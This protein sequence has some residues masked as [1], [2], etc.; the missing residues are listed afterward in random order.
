MDSED[1]HLIIY[2]NLTSSHPNSAKFSTDRGSSVIEERQ[3]NYDSECSFCG[4]V[5][6]S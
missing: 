5:C 6:L 3:N 4:Q 1:A 2:N